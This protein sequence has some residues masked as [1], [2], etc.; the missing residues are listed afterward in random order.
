MICTAS[1]WKIPYTF[2]HFDAS[3]NERLIRQLKDELLFTKA[4]NGEITSD[5][6][7]SMLGYE[8]PQVT[9]REL[10]GQTAANTCQ[11]RE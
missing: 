4:G 1:F 10:S 2:C 9:M 7:L 5:E 8:D 3:V 6:F 11:N